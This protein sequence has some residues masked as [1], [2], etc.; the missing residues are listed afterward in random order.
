MLLGTSRHEPK[1]A[2]PCLG[3]PRP[4]KWCTVVIIAVLDGATLT[5]LARGVDTKDTPEV[6]ERRCTEPDTIT[7]LLLIVLRQHGSLEGCAWVG[8]TSPRAGV[9]EHGEQGTNEA[10]GLAPAMLAGCDGLK[11]GNDKE[12]HRQSRVHDRERLSCSPATSGTEKGDERA[13]KDIGQVGERGGYQHDVKIELRPK[14][15]YKEYELLQTSPID[16]E[17]THHA[18][19]WHELARLSWLG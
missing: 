5:V 3:L 4:H 7:A 1:C 19:D 17:L 14:K 8:H 13:K 9:V 6:F 15:V 10:G 12:L 16:R 2:R 18:K 11:S